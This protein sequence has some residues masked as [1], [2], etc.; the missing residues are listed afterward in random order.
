MTGHSEQTANAWTARGGEFQSFCEQVA[1]TLGADERVVP[2]VAAFLTS[3][4][5]LPLVWFQF[6]ATSSS[7]DTFAR[8][9]DPWAGEM[10]FAQLP[11]QPRGGSSPP[12]LSTGVVRHVASAL[13]S[14]AGNYLCVVEGA[15]SPSVQ[16]IPGVARM[17]QIASDVCGQARAVLCVGT[18]GLALNLAM[19]S[20]AAA[21]V[22]TDV[23]GLPAIQVPGSPPT[24]VAF[25]ATLVTHLLGG[26]SSLEPTRPP[27][28]SLRV[29]RR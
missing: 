17:L 3:M 26:A 12:Q 11:T 10:V 19:T 23:A 13:R 24:A 5:R 20:A 14:C 25:A 18:A 15:P 21:P 8:C 4:R 28:P 29:V 22:L 1:T 27:P 6:G 16:A 2:R 7:G 9:T